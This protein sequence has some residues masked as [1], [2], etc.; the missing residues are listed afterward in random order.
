M[1]GPRG[2]DGSLLTS[3]P[4]TM[5]ALLVAFAPHVPYVPLWITGAFVGCAAWRFVVEKRRRALP[6]PWIRAGLA[7][8]C[9][10]GVL[11]TYSSISGVG[12]GSALLAVMAALKRC[13][14]TLHEMGAPRVSTNLRLGTRT[15]KKQ[16]MG[17]K[18]RSVENKL[19][20]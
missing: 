13:H 11:A 17:D 15:D 4:W 1:A 5:G 14:E 7:L 20:S 18:V 12:P 2:T 8:A 19:E 9:F 6:S 10:L 3:L 16:S